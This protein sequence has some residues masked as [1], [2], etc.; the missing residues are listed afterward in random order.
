MNKLVIAAV[1]AFGWLAVAGVVAHATHTNLTHAYQ[2]Q[3]VRGD[4]TKSLTEW[5]NSQVGWMHA[6]VNNTTHMGQKPLVCVEAFRRGGGKLHLGC[7]NLN[8]GA[9]GF[10]GGNWAESFNAPTNWIQKPGVYRVVYT[11]RDEFG[12]WH[13]IQ[14]PGGA[15][16]DG[17]VVH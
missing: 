3:V 2:P 12:K 1:I 17:V 6:R 7:L 4:T 13:R 8:L 14:G 16:Y 15:N 9:E 10:S 11:Y 5:P